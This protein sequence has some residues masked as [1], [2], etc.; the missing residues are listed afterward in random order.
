MFRYNCKRIKLVQG[1][2]DSIPDEK[3]SVAD[4]VD[5]FGHKRYHEK[6]AEHDLEN[7]E[8]K[9][10]KTKK[11][12]HGSDDEGRNKKRNKKRKRSM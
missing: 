5:F 12:K 7:P 10:S 4:A 2:D 9:K 8:G 1:K 6:S 11:F 3:E